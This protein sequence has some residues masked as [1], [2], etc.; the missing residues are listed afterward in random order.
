MLPGD[1]ELPRVTQ[2]NQ[3]FL[4]NVILHLKFL[5]CLPGMCC[6]PTICKHFIKQNSDLLEFHMESFFG[7][8]MLLDA[9]IL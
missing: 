2:T 4:Y 9:P 6:I 8:V 1:T 7:F 5:F 3:A